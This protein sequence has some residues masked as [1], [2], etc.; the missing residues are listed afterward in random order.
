MA[1]GHSVRYYSGENVRAKI[2]AAG[3][4]LV[5]YGDEKVFVLIS[6][7]HRPDAHEFLPIVLFL[8]LFTFAVHSGTLRATVPKELPWTTFSSPVLC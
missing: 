2:E 7:S 1:A 4:T 3:A 6:Q 5:P 8:S